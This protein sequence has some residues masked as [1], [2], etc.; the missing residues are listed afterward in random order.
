MRAA[1]RCGPRGPRAHPATA[2]CVSTNAGLRYGPAVSETGSST[3]PVT[4]GHPRPAQAPRRRH[5]P[6]RR[7]V[8]PPRVGPV[9]GRGGQRELDPPRGVRRHGGDRRDRRL[10][11]ARCRRV[12]RE[13]EQG[14]GGR[15]P[16]R[17]R[18]GRARARW[19][20]SCCSTA[21]TGPDRD[22]DRRAAP[23]RAP[24]GAVPRR[25]S[26]TPCTGR[27]WAPR[28]V[29]V[30]RLRD[31]VL[32]AGARPGPARSRGRR[33]PRTGPTDLR[34]WRR[35][36]SASAVGV[37]VTVT[38][39]DTTHEVLSDR[40]GY[41]DV[42]LPA[43]LEPGWRS[44][45]VALADASPADRHDRRGP[46]RRSRHPPRP[47]ERHRRHRDRDDAAAAPGRLPERV[48]APGERPHPG[49]GDGRAV[50]RRR[51]PPIPTCSSST[52]P[53]APGTPPAP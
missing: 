43:G 50:R 9:P 14:P 46:D 26:R 53:P 45:S 35:F 15:S 7:G 17:D 38:I 48:P 8:Q 13:H 34:G 32:G 36:L 10:G 31:D 20:S 11:A 42:R 2:G 30:R 5:P 16:R 21:S 52:C 41:V 49:P 1:E 6:R 44:V 51:R 24:A 33:P 29:R 28:L 37:P 12:A 22:V 25:S 39:G 19:S 27:G 40:D 23:R 18:D 47:G 3:E 4:Q